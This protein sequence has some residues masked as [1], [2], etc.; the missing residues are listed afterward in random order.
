MKDFQR[1]HLPAKR[2]LELVVNP[3]FGLIMKEKGTICKP[4]KKIYNRFYVVCSN[5]KTLFSVNNLSNIL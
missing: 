4:A 1:I 2:W 3:I 5:K